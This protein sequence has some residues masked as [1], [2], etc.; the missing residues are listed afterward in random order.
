MGLWGCLMAGASV[1]IHAAG[2]IEGGLTVSFEKLVTDV[3][4]L[5]MVAELCAGAQAGT[6]EIGYD[7]AI[8]EVEPQQLREHRRAKAGGQRSEAQGR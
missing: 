2:W 6:D 1:V 7:N 5:N 8:A 4:V 3:E